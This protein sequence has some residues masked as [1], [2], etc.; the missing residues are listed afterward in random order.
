MAEKYSNDS[1]TSGKDIAEIKSTLNDLATQLNR[2]QLSAVTPERRTVQFTES[3]PTRTHP[4]KPSPAAP[5]RNY[6]PF[7]GQR[8]QYTPIY[9]VS[10]GKR[11]QSG[12]PSSQRQE[13]THNGPPLRNKSPSPP[14]NSSRCNTSTH[15]NSRDYNK[16]SSSQREGIQELSRREYTPHYNSSDYNRS[17]SPWRNANQQQQYGYTCT[18]NREQSYNN[19]GYDTRDKQSYDNGSQQHTYTPPYIGAILHNYTCPPHILAITPYNLTIPPNSRTHLP[20]RLP[21]WRT[22][23][24]LLLEPLYNR[25]NV[26]LRVARTLVWIYGREYCPV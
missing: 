10:T 18:E 16:P 14:Y 17:S 1:V 22:S 11:L 25:N 21:Y 20:L 7:T 8:L 3:A 13:S 19:P 6:D 26:G 15:N 2:T 5:I 12:S 9:D 24:I 23:K 4:R